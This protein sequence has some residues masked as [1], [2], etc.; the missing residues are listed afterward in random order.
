MTPFAK[1]YTDNMTMEVIKWYVTVLKLYVI[2]Y[3]F[4]LRLSVNI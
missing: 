4:V 1:I 3:P 2:F